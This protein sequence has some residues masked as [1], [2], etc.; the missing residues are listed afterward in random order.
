MKVRANGKIY[1]FPDGTS[2]D[3]IRLALEEYFSAQG[4]TEVSG[5][6]SYEGRPATPDQ[7]DRMMGD[8]AP[9]ETPLLTGQEAFPGTGEIP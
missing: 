3:E 9:V 8:T 7:F 4:I 1:T 2:P 5:A 6:A